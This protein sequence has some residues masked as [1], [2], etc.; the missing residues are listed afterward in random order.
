MLNKKGESYMWEYDYGPN[1]ELKTQGVSEGR[2][3]VQG[4]L[5]ELANFSTSG[6]YSL[7]NETTRVV[8]DK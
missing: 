4:I 6:L 2:A 7:A 8:K 5:E 3:N 1:H